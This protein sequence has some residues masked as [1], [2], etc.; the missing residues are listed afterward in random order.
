LALVSLIP[1]RTRRGAT[2]AWLIAL[3]GLGTAAWGGTA[4]FTP[5]G[6]SLARPA[7]TGVPADVWLAGLAAS[8]ALAVGQRDGFLANRL[9]VKRMVALAVLAAVL[10]VCA[11]LWWLGRGI[12][13]PLTR[14]DPDVV[15][16]YVAAQ[17]GAALIVSGSIDD[18][19]NISV[20]R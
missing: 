13:D 16:S 20:V 3:L 11:G 4:A 19:L 10:P 1:M 6:S 17:P 8:C 14:S 5:A 18:G 2:F 9:H 7:W 15:P 12:D